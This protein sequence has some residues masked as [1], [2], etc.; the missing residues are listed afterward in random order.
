MSRVAIN[1]PLDNMQLKLNKRLKVLTL[2]TANVQKLEVGLRCVIRNF[3]RN[4]KYI[5]GLS[6]GIEIEFFMGVKQQSPDGGMSAKPR[7]MK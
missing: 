7:Y 1:G 3:A 4:S 2:N 5:L 6:D